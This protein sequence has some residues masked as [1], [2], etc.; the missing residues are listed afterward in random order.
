MNA[1]SDRLP[2]EAYCLNPYRLTMPDDPVRT[3]FRPGDRVRVR[4]LG[5]ADAV[6]ADA[7]DLA[8]AGQAATVAGTSFDYGGRQHVAV[9]IDGDP[10]RDLGAAGHVGHRFFFRPEELERANPAR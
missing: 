2:P 8:L 9:T 1:I 6:E 4:P 3:S 7:V 10:G 5:Q